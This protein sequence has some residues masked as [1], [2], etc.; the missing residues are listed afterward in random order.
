M[1]DPVSRIHRAKKV[2]IWDWIVAVVT[3]SSRRPRGMQPSTSQNFSSFLEIEECAANTNENIYTAL[4]ML[5]V[6]Y[7]EMEQVSMV[8]TSPGSHPSVPPLARIH[9]GVSPQIRIVFGYLRRSF[10]YARRRRVARKRRVR[11]DLQVLHSGLH[12]ESGGLKSGE[13]WRTIDNG[14]ACWRFWYRRHDSAFRLGPGAYNLYE[15]TG[16]T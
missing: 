12:F 15:E 3:V 14:K 4:G 6:A 2:R 1:R 16:I 9:G 7:R 11:S 13:A 10:F 8:P 5:M